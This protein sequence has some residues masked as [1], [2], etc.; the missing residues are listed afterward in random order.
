MLERKKDK[1]QVSIGGIRQLRSLPDALFVVDV[2][3]EAIAVREAKCLGIPVIGM[4]DTNAS[5][6]DVDF[7]IPANDDGY[8]SVEFFLRKIS[9][10]MKDAQD[11]LR[12][13]EAAKEKKGPVVKRK[14]TATVA[15]KKEEK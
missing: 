14:V 1:L 13:L 5:P 6:D 8:R 3:Q 10:V 7:M 11:K 9:G 2:K 15:A 4:V 12:T